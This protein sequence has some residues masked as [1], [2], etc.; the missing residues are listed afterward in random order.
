MFDFKFMFAM[1]VH[2]IP[3]KEWMMNLWTTMC[4]MSSLVMVVRAVK[5]VLLMKKSL[6]KP[7]M[8]QDT[9]RCIVLIGPVFTK[10]TPSI[11]VLGLIFRWIV[12]K[13]E[14]ETRK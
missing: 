5:S 6:K 11:I 14:E 12:D 8:C 3:S 4:L 2:V 13:E 1:I 7:G 10:F 9:P